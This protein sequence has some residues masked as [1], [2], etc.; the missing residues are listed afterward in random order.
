[1][2]DR[3]LKPGKGAAG[4]N[5]WARLS[6]TASFWILVFLIPVLILQVLGTRREESAELSYSQ[7]GEQLRDGNLLEVTIIDG[8]R[9]EG[10]LRTP[11]AVPNTNRKVR[12]F[13]TLLPF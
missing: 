3:E 13:W 9:V 11:M 7:F 8:K 6:K 1:M 4:G 2:A 5:R 10:V 12:Q